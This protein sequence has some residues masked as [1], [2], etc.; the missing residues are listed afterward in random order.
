MT[1]L[2]HVA[3][4]DTVH[5]VLWERLSAAGMECVHAEGTSREEVLAGALALCSGVVLRSRLTLDAELFDA[6]PNLKWVARSGA[7][8][9][10]IDLH[11]A[12]ARSIQVYSSPEGNAT[13]VGE[14]AVG[15]LLMLLHKLAAADRHVREGGWDR[16]GHRG[17]ELESRTVGIIGFGNMGRSFARRLTGFGCRVLAYDKYVSGFDGEFGVEEASLDAVRAAA[18]VVSLHIPLT[19]ETKGM[20]NR[21]WIAGFGHPFF[22]LNTARGEVVQTEAVLDAL[23]GGKL[24][25]AALDVLEFEKRSLEGLADRPVALERLLAHPLA[26]LSPHVAGWSVESYRKLSEVLAD[27]ILGKAAM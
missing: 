2:Q 5:E 11:A 21:D 22:L 14:H 18:D 8:L 12:E 6:M 20:V 1:E 7:G 15:Q 4:L 19:E 25:G 3:F 16:E 24:R 17:L 23:D 26:V 13:A 9:E 10:N 27:K